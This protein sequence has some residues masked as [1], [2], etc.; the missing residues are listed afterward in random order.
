MSKKY[1][2][3]EEIQEGVPVVCAAPENSRFPSIILACANSHEVAELIACALNAYSPPN[4]ECDICN[5]TGWN[6]GSDSLCFKCRR[7]TT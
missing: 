7:R 4:P 3:A 1:W 5:G 6:R 2:A